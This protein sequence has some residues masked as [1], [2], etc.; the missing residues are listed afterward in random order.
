MPKITRFNINQARG[1][2]MQMCWVT[3][4]CYRVTEQCT[5]T[6]R[7]YTFI[8]YPPRVI[9]KCSPNLNIDQQ[10]HSVVKRT[11]NEFTRMDTHLHTGA[12]TLP[13]KKGPAK[14]TW[15]LCSFKQQRVIQGSHGWKAWLEV[16]YG[17]Q[18]WTNSY[19]K[20]T[21]CQE[22]QNTPAVAPLHPWE[23]PKHRSTRLHLDYA[24]PFLG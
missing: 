18:A 21:N 22:S 19:K 4:H 14:C 12:A 8:G 9:S 3:C 5:I 10:R 16:L 6:W 20:V 2:L 7:N 13:T 24:G 11:N 15:W 1:T 17:G 23:W